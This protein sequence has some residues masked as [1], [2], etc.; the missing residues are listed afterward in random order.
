MSFCV[1]S[2]QR[3]LQEGVRRFCS[4]R[5]G[6]DVL[7]RLEGTGGFDHN[8]WREL[9]E[10]GVF[11]LQLPAAA[12]G[13]GL[14]MPEAVLVFEELG[15]AAAPGPLLWTH[16]AAGLIDGAGSGARIVTGLDQLGQSA[17]RAPSG[18]ESCANA[19]PS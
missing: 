19:V 10:L 14:G 8:L 7:R 3:A 16:L 18:P 6:A 15:R 13:A 1:N 2:D 5:L 17:S 11:G 4:E 9:A 12:G